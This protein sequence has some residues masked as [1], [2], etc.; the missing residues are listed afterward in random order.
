MRID[1]IACE[2]IDDLTRLS[3]RLVWE[4]SERREETLW[5]EWPSLRDDITPAPAALLVA[6]FPLAIVTGERRVAMDSPVCAFLCDHLRNVGEL[7]SQWFPPLVSSSLEVPRATA[8]PAPSDGRRAA[9]CLSGGVDS[10]AALVE[11]HAA[12]APGHPERFRDGLFLFG[13][14]T[15]D[16]HEGTPIAA[17][18]AWYQ[19]Y[20]RRLE[21][22][23]QRRGLT[24][25][26]IATNVRALY[27]DWAGWSD[28]GQASALAA[29]A[30]A[31]PRRI[32]AL[33]I[34]SGGVGAGGSIYSGSEPSLDPLYSSYSLDVRSVQATLSRLEKVRLIVQDPDALAVL[35][36]CLTFDV[37]PTA[38]AGEM[39]E[40]A[41][42][43]CGHCEKCLRTML[44]LIV[45]D[46]LEH[47][48]T[49][50]VRDVKAHMLEGLQLDSRDPRQVP[51]YRSM[52]EPLRR[53]GREDLA[54][55]IRKRVDEFERGLR[56]RN[57]TGLRRLFR[58]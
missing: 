12:V 23:S 15:Y 49:F 26:R 21:T 51:L 1:R 41:K 33:T 25:I 54:D 8:L 56:A 14:N 48:P 18:L 5:Y 2:T 16:F 11:N 4:D 53:R 24:L 20:G 45:C 36:V 50:P 38:S 27:P 6:A 37:P 52:L 46:A 28:V 31:L 40:A 7:F 43:N 10:L 30:H 42:I 39:A 13:L 58:R 35:R 19:E 9:L 44:A 22:F 47:A 3:A 29:A 17:R 57:T 55:A 32:H 34:A